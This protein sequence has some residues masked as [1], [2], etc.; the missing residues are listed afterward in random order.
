M[1]NFMLSEMN[2]N[3]NYDLITKNVFELIEIKCL[4]TIIH[5]QYMKI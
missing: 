5:L 4:R 1:K 3:F 2:F